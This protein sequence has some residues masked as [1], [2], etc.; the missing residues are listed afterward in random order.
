MCPIQCLI[1]LPDEI[2]IQAMVQ[3]LYTLTDIAKDEIMDPRRIPKEGMIK[4]G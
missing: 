2:G 1:G 3:R 4:F